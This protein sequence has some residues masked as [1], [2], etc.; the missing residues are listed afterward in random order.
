MALVVLEGVQQL[1]VVGQ[2]EDG[3][4]NATFVYID[5]DQRTRLQTKEN[6][7]YLLQ[8]VD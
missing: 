3:L 8:V 5:A 1:A 6:R 7:I 4:N 2:E